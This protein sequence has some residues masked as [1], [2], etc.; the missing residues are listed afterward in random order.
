MTIKQRFKPQ[1]SKCVKKLNTLDNEYKTCLIDLTSLE[2]EYEQVYKKLL[3]NKLFINVDNTLFLVKEVWVDNNLYNSQNMPEVMCEVYVTTYLDNEFNY[4]AELLTASLNE[5][6][7]NNNGNKVV[8]ELKTDSISK[9]LI[10]Q[11]ITDSYK[12][13]IK[14]KRKK[15]I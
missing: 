11:L 2:N 6:Y 4:K 10:V 5:W 15:N 9:D 14:L 1:F 3:E 8:Q 7:E 12:N 13:K